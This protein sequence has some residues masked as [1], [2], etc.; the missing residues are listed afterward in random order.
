MTQTRPGVLAVRALN[1]YRR[2][3]VLAYLGLRYYLHNSV[4]R[5]DQWIRQVATK[6]VMTRTNRPYFPAQHFK[7]RARMGEINHRPIFLPGANEALAETALLDECANHEGIFTNPKCVFS[8]HLSQ[9][10]DRTGAFKHYTTGLRARHKAIAQACDANPSGIV[11]YLDIQRFYPSIKIDLAMRTWKKYAEAAGLSS[12]F[13]ELG[14]RLIHDHGKTPQGNGTGI[15]TGPIFSHLLANLVLREFDEELAAKLP[16][17]YFRYVDDITLVGDEN[18]IDVSIQEIQTRLGD[19]GFTLH[20]DNSPKSIEVPVATW[21]E[22]RNDYKEGNQKFSWMTLI[23][24]LKRFLLMNPAERKHVQDTFCAEGI[25]IPVYDYS[26]A[27][28]ERS[29]LERL[30]NLASQRWFKRKAQRVSIQTLISQAVSLRDN[31]ERE[32]REMLAPPAASGFDRKRLIPK[33]RYRAGRLA[34]LSS[35][36]SLLA[37]ANAMNEYP[38]LHFHA[39]VMTA[40]STAKLDRILSLGTNAAQATAQPLRAA[41]V[42]C[43]ISG[44]EMDKVLEQSFA[45]FILNGVQVDKPTSSQSK[46]SDLLRFALSG[47]DIELM[48]SADPFTR[49]LACL[50]GLSERPRHPETLE[51]VF[52]KDENL[53]IDAIEQL[54]GS[55]SP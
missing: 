34:Y 3:D 25:R 23:G 4:A 28:Q 21:L 47:A 15:L 8:Y 42:R 48:K 54:Q 9:G 51:S 55:V 16:G 20:D 50:H 11:R 26:A 33:L 1:Q 35:P 32:L 49:E 29:F 46:K 6:L 24:D 14:E 2:R 39:E 40:I 7:E 52:D 30:S 18:S 36:E 19:L 13:L 53:A 27:A 37:L 44:G 41:G 43:N 17:R 22:G 45:V 31:Y 5:S 38:E 12:E 10:D